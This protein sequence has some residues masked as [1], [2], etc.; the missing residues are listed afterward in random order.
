MAFILGMFAVLALQSDVQE[1]IKE[2]EK[3]AETGSEETQKQAD[4]EETQKQAE[5][6]ATKDVEKARSE[7][8][9]APLVGLLAIVV[10]LVFSPANLQAMFKQVSDPAFL[11]SLQV[12]V[13]PQLPLMGAA[14]FLGI[15]CALALHN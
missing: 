13:A 4:S 3:Q 11:L 2:D 15:P 5:S 12:N 8:L 6:K 9:F 14:V 1:I 10:P 7:M